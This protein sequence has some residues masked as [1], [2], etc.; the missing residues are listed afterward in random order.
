MVRKKNPDAFVEDRFKV[1][2]GWTVVPGSPEW[3][4][5]HEGFELRTRL[6]GGEHFT[7]SATTPGGPN[8]FGEAS[9]RLSAM[10]KAEFHVYMYE[11]RRDR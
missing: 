3:A 8:G 10:R 9:S 2:P 7:W 11:R 1:P 6:I 5:T 4:R